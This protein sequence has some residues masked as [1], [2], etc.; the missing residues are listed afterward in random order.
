MAKTGKKDTRLG[1][2]DTYKVYGPKIDG[3]TEVA[4]ASTRV[5]GRTYVPEED[6]TEFEKGDKAR[7]LFGKDHP[8]IDVV[9]TSNGH[10]QKWQAFE[11]LIREY[12]KLL[13]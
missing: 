8:G 6:T 13:V 10:T 7:V 1:K 4:P 5:K 9:D 2:K 11:A 3:A 12:V